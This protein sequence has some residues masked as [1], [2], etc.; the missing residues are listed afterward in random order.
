MGDAGAAESPLR[1]AGAATCAEQPG[2]EG[3]RPV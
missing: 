3:V 2:A 1:E